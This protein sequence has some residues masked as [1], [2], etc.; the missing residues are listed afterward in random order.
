MA[1]I[2]VA[3]ASRAEFDVMTDFISE[4]GERGSSTASVVN[5]VGFIFTGALYVVFAVALSVTFSGRWGWAFAA[6][7][8]VLDGIGRMGAGVYPCDP[9]CDGD[10]PTQELHRLFA[11]IGFSS[12]ILAALVCGAL[13][14]RD[15][16]WRGFGW[17]ACATGVIA[18]TLLLAM[19]LEWSPVP[20]L[21]EHLAS[22]LLSI[23]LLVLAARLLRPPDPFGSRG[24]VR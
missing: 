6:V 21:I 16:G 11:T 20:G 19:S 3:G 23:W 14:R 7:L 24:P 17:Y 22:A 4:L 18:A 1:L 5:P 10:S 15:A 2:G 12:G 13:V 9:G 8:L